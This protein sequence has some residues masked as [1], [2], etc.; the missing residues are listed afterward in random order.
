MFEV[1]LAER[2]FVADWNRNKMEC[3]EAAK[4]Y[5]TIQSDDDLDRAGEIQT[6]ISKLIKKL[7]TERKAITSPLDE[8]KKKIMAEEK[9][10][11]KPLADELDR[12]KKIT[13]AY[14][15]E[16]ARRIEE[17]R[18][19]AEL[20]ER[21]A[22]EAAVAAEDAD[23]F[24]FNA[25]ATPPP[26]MPIP[27]VSSMPKT[28]CNRMVERWDFE[29]LDANAVPKELC[30]PDPAKIRAFLASRKAEGYKAD[31]V[32]VNGLKIFSTVQVQSR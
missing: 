26:A 10:L 30:S 17:E 21:R 32:M 8:A 27:Q 6:N 15:T 31:Q 25:P 18:R 12:L 23:P 24:G 28:S 4:L 5:P 20:A 19:Q 29:V 1:A 3:L 22:A 13:S 9:R 2:D 14:A 7:E 16:C 11:V